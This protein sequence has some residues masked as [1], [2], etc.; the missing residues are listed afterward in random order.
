[1]PGRLFQS[2]LMFEVKARRLTK[3]GTPE[4]GFTRVSSVLSHKHKTRVGKSSKEPMLYVIT[5][6][7]NIG[8]SSQ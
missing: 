2:S 1:M 7:K 4:R 3:S 6:F 5:N 8:P